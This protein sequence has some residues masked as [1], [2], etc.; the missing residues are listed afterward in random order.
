M[1]LI[2]K[3][4]EQEDKKS[5]CIALLKGT[6]AMTW[7]DLEN[8][9]NQIAFNLRNIYHV[10]VNECIAVYMK[11]SFELLASLLGVFKVGAYYLP[12]HDDF[13]T[14]RKKMLLLEA[15]DK[16]ILS[17]KESL[18]SETP[19]LNPKSIDI[20][21]SE[22]ITKNIPGE[23][24]YRIYT[25]G[26][27]GKPKGVNVTQSNL[28]YILEN[29][30]SMFPVANNDA[31]LLS[32]P[33]SFDVSVTELFSWIYGGGKLVIPDFEEPKLVFKNIPE[34]VV[35]YNITHMALSPSVLRVFLKTTSDE[36]A[37]KV[38]KTLKYLM[39]AG[40]EFPVKIANEALEK[41]PD[42]H[43]FNLYG[44]TEGTVYATCFPITKKCKKTVPIGKPLKGAN[45]VKKDKTKKIS[46]LII[47]GNGVANGYWNQEKKTK[48]VFI[49]YDGQTG[50]LT[51]DL[52]EFDHDGNIIYHGRIDDQIEING[53]R[54]ESEEVIKAAN[55]FEEISESFVIYNKKRL[56]LFYALQFP[57]KKERIFKRLKEKLPKYM[58]PHKLVCID[59]FPITL[60][61]KIDKKGLLKLL[62]S[63]ETK[64][65]ANI[66]S[67]MESNLLK[68]LSKCVDLPIK[69]ITENTDFYLDLGID[70]L[71][72]IEFLIDL[73]KELGIDIPLEVLNK[74]TTINKLTAYLNN[75][76]EKQDEDCTRN[77]FVETVKMEIENQEFIFSKLDRRSNGRSVPL[78]HYQRNYLKNKFNSSLSF[79]T[80]VKDISEENRVRK[81]VKQL[82]ATSDALKSTI[83]KENNYF[84][85]CLNF[86]NFEIPSTYY[87]ESKINKDILDNACVN[88]YKNN[89]YNTPLFRIMFL[90]SK[91]G[92]ISLYFSLSHMICDLSS[93]N[94]IS[95][96]IKSEKLKV[97]TGYLDYLKYINDSSN[98]EEY[99]KLKYDLL[100]PKLDIPKI[101]TSQS[102]LYISNFGLL[103]NKE[104]TM[105]ELIISVCYQ[106]ARIICDNTNLSR[107]SLSTILTI[108]KMEKNDFSN[109]IGDFHESIPFI[110]ESSD[111]KKEFIS[112]AN[113]LIKLIKSGNLLQN[114]LDKKQN[115]KEQCIFK[116]NQNV[117]VDFVGYVMDNDIDSLYSSIQG[118]S[119]F[120]SAWLNDGRLRVTLFIY[121]G[122]L[123]CIWQNQVEELI[124]N[125]NKHKIVTMKLE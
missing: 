115:K 91:T 61:G 3:F 113:D 106:L 42:V 25:S 9:S 89:I 87:E 63:S 105:E 20:K 108:R 118:L 55:S 79:V 34:E 94:Y 19:V 15:S 74:Y 110:Y 39:I 4:E 120:N 92:K 36:L 69:Q 10:D 57:L 13:P 62:L 44:P 59:K 37:Y 11:P 48:D 7:S 125:L 29:M 60:N 1:R 88:S 43:L 67:N 26:S 103:N 101:K 18:Y 46:E 72:S 65:S 121:F 96:I 21:K 14:E 90:I 22:K 53:I 45:I 50:Y 64:A 75:G 102:N 30:N 33:I 119:E 100:S 81:N 93:I 117:K 56:I 31:Y 85:E 2:D 47:L 32:T 41:F 5:D 122:N 77:N 71:T 73:E 58:V 6:K 8:Y 99:K 114:S 23:Y 97:R 12:I 83:K 104:D 27:T 111:S 124:C 35:D 116:R 107:V 78:G 54:V 95:R 98:L 49:D 38:N 82:L 40:E 86:D 70:S 109:I 68:I 123:Y 51:G 112:N 17:D 76:I 24:A 84:E 28:E 66:T 16:V 80:S 52:G